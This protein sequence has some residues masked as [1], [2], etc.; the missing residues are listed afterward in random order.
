MA[1]LDPPYVPLNATSFVGYTSD[2]FDLK[3]HKKLFEMVNELKENK[4]NWMMS[5]SDMKLVT[6]NFSDNK[7]Y[8]IEK[9]LCKRAI[10][11]KKPSSK[12][13]EVVI[14]SY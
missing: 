13:N 4:I 7:K 3:L 2:G 12:T 14:K 6:D 10:H 8:S 5:N 11:S 1:Y 9:I